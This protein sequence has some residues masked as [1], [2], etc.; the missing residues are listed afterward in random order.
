MTQAEL[1]QAKN[2]A[3]ER[4]AEEGKEH[5]ERAGWQETL[6]PEGVIS[7]HPRKVNNKLDNIKRKINYSPQKGH[8][9]KG[10][11]LDDEDDI[12]YDENAC[13]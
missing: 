2:K 8:A 12:A 6:S 9:K 1:F 13:A 3:M 4:T 10:D 5:L 11:E 7:M